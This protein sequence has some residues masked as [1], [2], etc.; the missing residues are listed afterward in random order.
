M[1][2]KKQHQEKLF[3]SFQLS[4]YVPAENFYRQ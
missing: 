4:E 2:G 3:N 1:Q